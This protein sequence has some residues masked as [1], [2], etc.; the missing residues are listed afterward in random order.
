MPCTIGQVLQLVYIYVYSNKKKYLI[1][2]WR[3]LAFE[4]YRIR[5]ILVNDFENYRID[6]SIAL[7]VGNLST[8]IELLT[9]KSNEP[10][11]DFCNKSW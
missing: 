9:T 4:L 10:T 8:S 2:S 3:Y 11:L 6:F 5:E 1:F 7:A